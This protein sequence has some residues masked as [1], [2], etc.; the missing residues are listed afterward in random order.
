MIDKNQC[1]RPRCDV[2]ESEKHISIA[3]VYY[4]GC[5]VLNQR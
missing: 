1:V 3:V 5:K 2:D 4:I